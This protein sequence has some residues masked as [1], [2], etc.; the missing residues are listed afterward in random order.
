MIGF[1][2]L[3]LRKDN[4]IAQKFIEHVEKHVDSMFK[5]HEKKILNSLRFDGDCDIYNELEED[6][7]DMD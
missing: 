5:Q 4:Q 2:H 7:G 1:E 6:F 3:K